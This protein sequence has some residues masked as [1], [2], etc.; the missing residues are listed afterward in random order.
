MKIDVCN[1]TEIIGDLLHTL[2]VILYVQGIDNIANN[3][4]I[5]NLFIKLILDYNS[6]CDKLLFTLIDS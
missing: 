2:D 4:K 6:V 1:I 5:S 3:I